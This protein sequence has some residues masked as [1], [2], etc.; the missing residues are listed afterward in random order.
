MSKS[1]LE[2]SSTCILC[3]CEK[4]SPGEPSPHADVIRTITSCADQFIVFIFHC[5][6]LFY[7]LIQCY[8][9]NS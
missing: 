9:L 4:Q 3:L 5:G 1:C 2:F 8:N 7:F 6:P